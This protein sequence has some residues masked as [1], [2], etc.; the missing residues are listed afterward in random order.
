VDVWFI[1]LKSLDICTFFKRDNVKFQ[2]VSIVL[3]LIS[4]GAILGPVGAVVIIYHNDFTQLVIPPQVRD[5]MN[6]NSS[7]IPTGNSDDQNSNS[8]MGGLMQPVFVS[9][10]SDPESHTFT[11]IFQVTNS[12]NYDLTLNS[13]DASVEFT[14]NQIP[15]GDVR[16]SSPVAVP[17]G[18]TTQLTISGHWTQQVQ[19]YFTSNPSVKSVDVYV[20]N[21]KIDVN[22]IIIQSS[23][24]IEVGYMPI[25][26]GA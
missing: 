16:L 18:Q 20:S 1:T 15:A 14:S 19:E 23:D 12:F 13:F 21:V 5:L 7:L 9:A 8:H 22:G 6:G 10:T 17:A 24:T 26:S 25:N 2:L 3:A 11:G 4:I